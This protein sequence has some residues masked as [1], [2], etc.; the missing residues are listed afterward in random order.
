VFCFYNGFFLKG[1]II[2]PDT[3]KQN[4]KHAIVKSSF[5]DSIKKPHD[6][7]YDK[8]QPDSLKK[9]SSHSLI[10]RI[11]KPT[12][13]ARLG[14]EGYHTSFQNPRVLSEPQ[15]LR[16]NGNASVTW[17]RMPLLVDFYHTSENQTIYNSNYIKIRFD[18]ETYINGIKQGWQKRWQESTSKLN[19]DQLQKQQTDKAQAALEKQKGELSEKQEKLN[20]NLEEKMKSYQNQYALKADSLLYNYKDSFK[21][22]WNSQQDSAKNK[23]RNKEQQQKDSANLERLRQDSQRIAER[24][25]EIERKQQEYKEKRQQ[26]DSIITADS[27]KLVYYQ[28]LLEDPQGNAGAWLKEKGF[29][30]QLVAFSYLKD[31]QI[32]VVNPLIH[33]YSISGIGIKG[34]TTAVKV[35]RS[36]WNLTGGKAIVSDL[37]YYNRTNSK[38]ER[39][40]LAA[41]YKYRINKNMEVLFFAHHAKDPENKFTKENRTAFRNSNYG[42]QIIANPKNLVLIDASAASSHY[43]SLNTAIRNVSYP[44]GGSLSVFD[45]KIARSAYM[46]RLEKAVT[47]WLSLEVSDHYVGPG[48]KNLGNPFMR[49][50]FRE[51]KIKSKLSLF[52]DQLSITAFYKSLRDNPIGLSEITNRTSGYGLSLQT[53]FKNKKLPNLNASVS[54]YEQGNNHPDSLFRVNSK[55]SIMTAGLTWRMSK[56]RFK[57]FLLIYGSQS[58]MRF[59][60]TFMA[61]VQTLSFNQDFVFG[62]HLTFGAGGNFVRTYPA[63]DSTQVNIWQARMGYLTN[64]GANLMLNA[65]YAQYLNGAFR[66]GAALS[67][68]VPVGKRYRLV[69]K[70]GYDHYYRLWGIGD[71]K[72]FSGLVRMEIRI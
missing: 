26:Y 52:Q 35:G 49:T 25:Q 71:Q 46:I 64:K 47:K 11:P 3:I 41:S 67:V 56:A 20:K 17:F 15:Y 28:K 54:P 33:N 27:A 6:L 66:K 34:F 32:G 50:N 7:L 22:S 37:N 72:A 13:Q 53:R 63:I 23:F 70:A 59:N 16:I 43:Q 58:E 61:K 57:Y 1:Q 12:Y 30:K 8:R 31:F 9:D 45:Y 51:Q 38:Y 69:A 19:A 21:E 4:I 55:F 2:F 10:S 18:Y 39:F 62:K 5:V 24:I 14:I 68:A 44:G 36:E 60:D 29:S 65:Q 42:M 48:F 40:I